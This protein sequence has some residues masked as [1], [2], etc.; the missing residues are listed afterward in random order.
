MRPAAIVLF[1]LTPLAHA[2]DVVSPADLSSVRRDFESHAGDQPLRCEVT[3]IPSAI[4]FA[5]RFTAGYTL[6][7]PR[8]QYS[9]STTGWSVLT[10]IVPESGE[11]T[12]LLSHRRLAEAPAVGSNFEI[13]GR[14]F[15]GV[16]HY[17][18]ETTLRDDRSRVCRKHW[19]V[20]VAPARAD[21]TIPL[22]LPLNAVRGY[23]P[24]PLPDTGSPDDATP[25]RLTILLN[26]AAFSTRRTVIR[27][28]ERERIA[29][30]LTALLE[31][32]PTTSLRLV[33]FSLEQQQEIL[34]TDSFR[35]DD[36]IKV[37][38]SI[39]A[40]PQ[41][42][43]DVKV[44]KNPHGHVDFLAGLIDRELNRPDAA[45]TVV[46]L[47]PTSRYAD[48]APPSAM[49]TVDGSPP[50]FFYV[51]YEGFLRPTLGDR[52]T[53]GSRRLQA[54]QH[55]PPRLPSDPSHGRPDIITKA[56]ARLNGKTMIVHTPAE[57]AGAIRKI[58]IRRDN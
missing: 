11:P 7:V 50:R 38:D 16:G 9:P 32:L 22:A 54:A 29:G 49:A 17:S 39:D 42:T 47:G 6:H 15:L 10:A 35:P 21:R 28:A 31:H 23:S 43:V 56:V 52:S 44:L 24:I 4:D 58:E 55:G 5:F 19:R 27:E 46:F 33:V 41:A 12:Y 18:V 36:V 51:R 34:R 8:F 45:D 14:Y 25:M 1:L 57:L 53:L 37:A 3:P 13:R 30:G 48:K 2:Q 40:V 20:A 26:A